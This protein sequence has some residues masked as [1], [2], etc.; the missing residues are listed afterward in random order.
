MIVHVL[1]LYH[2][3]LLMYKQVLLAQVICIYNDC[4]VLILDEI[5]IRAPVKS[6]YDFIKAV[7]VCFYIIFGYTYFL[8]P[9]MKNCQNTHWIFIQ[10][11]LISHKQ[12]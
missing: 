3:E 6:Y 5:H 10:E 7:M 12:L 2:I 8:T 11:N 9:L 4:S 1:P